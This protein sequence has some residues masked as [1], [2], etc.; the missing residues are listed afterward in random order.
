M[1]ATS[2][3]GPLSDDRAIVASIGGLKREAAAAVELRSQAGLGNTYDV[4]GRYF[5]D[6][7]G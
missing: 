5:M 2:L 6:Y 3:E 4:V 1:R 7:P